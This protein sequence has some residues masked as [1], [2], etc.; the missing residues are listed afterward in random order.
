MQVY[1]LM[2]PHWA[3]TLRI[4]ANARSILVNAGGLVENCWTPGDYALEV[5]EGGQFKE[6]ET[7]I[8][9]SWQLRM[10]RTVCTE[11][12]SL[13]AYVNWAGW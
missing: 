11:P 5:R 10:S 8:L 12:S 6:N 9:F 4:N 2:V 13:P 3:F 1:K 7:A